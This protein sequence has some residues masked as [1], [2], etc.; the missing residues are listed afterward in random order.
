MLVYLGAVR[1]L[2]FL[3]CE[4]LKGLPIGR[5]AGLLE[6]GKEREGEQEGGITEQPRLAKSLSSHYSGS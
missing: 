6:G 2:Q 1:R 5:A 4:L 3:S